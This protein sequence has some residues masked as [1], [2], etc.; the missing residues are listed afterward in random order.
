MKNRFLIIG[1]IALI[2]IATI[3]VFAN[4]QLDSVFEV[5]FQQH[6]KFQEENLNMKFLN[7]L[8]DSR[9]P[10]DVTCVWQG[11]TSLSFSV[12]QLIKTEV[13]LDTLEKNNVAVF[14]KYQIELIDVNPYPNSSIPTKNDD[15]TALLRVSKIIQLDGLS[16]LKQQKAGILVN[17]VQCKN[18]MHVLTIRTNGKIAC[19][20]ETTA[21]KLGWK[22][23]NPAISDESFFEIVKNGEFF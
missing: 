15:Y 10:T 2:P 23:I 13:I 18:E 22:L 14:G 21:E 20:Y 5:Q 6:A 11:R 4:P 12:S 3:P 8:E 16:P 17:D 1:I 19:A 7:V 9:C